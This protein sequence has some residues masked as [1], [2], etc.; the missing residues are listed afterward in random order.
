MAHLSLCL[1]GPFQVTLDGRPLT[2]FKSNK[3]RALLAYLA[4]EADRPHR[5]EVLAGLL[6]PEWPDRDALSNLRYTLSNLRQV[7]GDRPGADDPDT[8]QPCLLVTRSTLQFNRAS[9]HWVDVLAFGELVT[10]DESDPSTFERLKEAV[11][12]YRGGFL[13]GFSL[14]DSPAFEEWA[15]LTRE[16]IAR[17]ASSALH[18]LAAACEQRGH[19]DEAQSYAYRQLEL[20]PWDESAHRQLMRS[21]VLSGQR[22]AALA[23]YETCR[24]LL[25][26][27]L[28]VEPGEETT[29]LYEQ[30]RDGSLSRV[31]RDRTS[32]E[33]VIVAPVPSTGMPTSEPPSFLG[34]E[35]ALEVETPVFVARERELARL[36]AFLDLALRGEGRVVFVTGEA[37]SGKT[38]LV[39]AFT[40]RAQQVHPHL[41]VASGDCNAYT[42]IGDPYLPFRQIL[43]SLTGD[44]EARW[45]AGTITT[46]RARRL[47]SILPVTAQALVEQAPDLIDTF[48]PRGALLERVGLRAQAACLDTSALQGGPGI[49][50]ADRTGWLTRLVERLEQHP[51]GASIPSPHQL[52]IFEQYSRVLRALGR[53]VPLVLMLDD[54]QWADA[55]SIHLLFH[56]GRQ[57]AG[58]RLL[59]VGIYRG[60]EVAIGRDGDQHPLEPVIDELRRSFGDVTIDLGQ[61]ESRDF[62]EALLDSEPNRLGRAFRA[63]LYWQTRGHPLFTIELLRGLQQRGDLV[64]DTE[65]RWVAG[66]K[67]DWETLPG[68]V[69]AVIAGR[70]GRLDE[71]LRAALRVASVEGE[72]FT[73]EVLARVQG[74]DEQEMLNC[75]SRQLDRRHRLVQAESIQRI[76]G[77]TVSRYRFR[78]ILFQKYLYDTLDEVER[79]HL[80]ERVGIALEE[81][82]GAQEEVEEIAV[83]LALHFRK[84]QLANK[85][86][87]YLQQAGD[88]A[89]QVSAYPEAISHLTLGLDLLESL[90]DTPERAEKELALQVSLSMARMGGIPS[91]EW[92]KAVTRARELSHRMGKT[93]QFCRVLG[94]MAI[95]HYVRAEYLKAREM[96]EETLRVAQQ[97][98]D[99]LLVALSHWYLGFI[100]F[101]LGEHVRA[102]THLE[103]MISFYDPEHHHQAYLSMR[104]SDPGVSALAYYTSCLWCLGY[105]EQAAERNRETLALAR[106]FDHPF[107]LADVICFGGCILNQ[108]R[109]DAPALKE[110]AEEL[111]RISEGMWSPSFLGQGTA[112][113]GEA[114]A[115]MDR[116]EQGIRQIRQ[117]MVMSQSIDARCYLSGTL[118]ALATAQAKNGQPEV[119]L[120]TVS[121]AL[122][123]VEKTEERYYEPELRRLRGEL[124]LAQGDHAEAK[125]SFLK[126]IE[127]ARRQRAKSWELRSTVSLC[128]LWQ[129]QGEQEKAQKRLAQIYGWF[130][131]GFDTPDL[132]EAKALLEELAD[133]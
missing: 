89:V 11:G 85:A 12:L 20:E 119:A 93:S 55:G 41:I 80:H 52:A 30:I 10:V 115:Q 95:L 7:I 103:R 121:D 101:G 18:Q 31:A 86:I 73:A 84:A 114:L 43:E 48:V 50:G 126:A 16:Q 65:G 68:R 47:W 4:T 8:E 13:E 122:A 44:V 102:R 112:F 67:L 74:T 90:P 25:A 125:T 92:A 54:L 99:P 133:V 38:A 49:A 97:A 19:Y 35:E 5:R 70:V 26:E 77:G 107:T 33:A 72:H 56:L 42:G 120:A 132:K 105:P 94:E 96:A 116:V 9:D 53:Q 131:E 17:Q 78:H 63:M 124:F 6:W 36:K 32:R 76:D 111:M 14:G 106:V 127:V 27:E 59:I 71:P 21:L 128:R 81:L 130:T 123:M 3:V 117:G 2:G 69:E 37:G 22:S 79:V 45:A 88:K 118:G 29:R 66:P 61:A 110:D 82:Y 40:R 62:M 24:R 75:L 108:M 23:Q 104:G 51:S 60:E 15:L 58:R 34:A 57:L 109:R 39:Q 113:R 100:N 83:Q 1:L 46:E 91:P 98:D 28:G 87:H 64:Q 129:K